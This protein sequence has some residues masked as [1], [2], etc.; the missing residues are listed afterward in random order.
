[1]QVAGGHSFEKFDRWMLNLG[2]RMRT[3]SLAAA[4]SGLI[5][6]AALIWFYNYTGV[7]ERLPERPCSVH[8]SAFTQR[9]SIAQNYAN[10]DMNFFKPR[11]NSFE[12]SMGISG[13]EFPVLYYL[14]AICYRLFGFNDMYLKLIHLLVFSAGLFFFF[15]LAQQFLRHL[16]LSL[17]LICA[18]ASS[19]VLLYYSSNVSPDAAALGLVLIAWYYF[20]QYLKSQQNRY[21]N[22]FLFFGVLAGLIKVIMVMCFCV[23][24]CLLVL[25]QMRFFKDQAG[26]LLFPKK[27]RMLI[28]LLTAFAVVALWYIYCKILTAVYGNSPSLMQTMM[29]TDREMLAEVWKYA[30]NFIP[31]YYA[32]E[33]YVLLVCATA[34]VL[35][36]MRWGNRLLLAIMFCYLL[37]SVCYLYLFLYQFMH[38]DYYVIAML[39][40]IFFL[41][42]IFFD[43]VRRLAIRYSQLILVAFVI[44]MIFNVKESL[45]K[46]R[47]RYAE[48]YDAKVYYS[49]DF[50]PYYDLGPRLRGLGIRWQ[51]KVAVAFDN[52]FSASLYFMDQAGY[53]LGSESSRESIAQII[54]RPDVNYLVLSDSSKFN[55]IYPNDFS[56]QIIL[57]HR[58]LIVYKLK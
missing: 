22:L 16:A 23:V 48:R 13:S 19:T 42:L 57:Y 39:P 21:F 28:S 50:K 11:F 44:V 4:A 53:T 37:G 15:R 27:K 49:G 31:D 52:T 38:H 20:F 33:G 29:V 8:V 30:K 43:L 56:K 47:K 9:A 32:Y 55:R 34:I 54:E 51:D 3:H 25:D 41:L 7:F 2:D 24:I 5:F 1:M 46:T 12:T 35:A 17:L 14:A 10:I 36:G 6:V 45:V 18:L 26:G 40:V 58:G